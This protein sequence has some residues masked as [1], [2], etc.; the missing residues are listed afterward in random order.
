MSLW[1]D[2][3][4]DLAYMAVNGRAMTRELDRASGPDAP[5]AVTLPELA[6]G[7][8]RFALATIFTEPGGKGPESYPEGDASRAFAVGR[9]Q[10][11]VYLTWRDAGLVAFD[12]AEQL[13]PDDP[14]VGT[15]AGGMGVAGFT[16]TPLRERLARRR[17]GPLSIGILVENA[18]PIRSPDELAWWVERGVVAVGLAWAKPSRYAGGNTSATGLTDLGRKM[19]AEMDRLGVVH[20]A[21]HLSDAAMDEL[22]EES[23]GSVIASH[24][25]CRALLAGGGFGVNQRHLRDESIRAI[26]E[27]GGVVGLNLFAKFLDPA[28]AQST[29]GRPTIADCIRHVEH[30]CELT[31]SRR[32]VGLGSDMDG[33]FSAL[34][35]PEGIDSPRQLDRLADALAARGWSDDD[36]FNFRIGNWARVFGA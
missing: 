31:R 19:V 20:D 26:A 32:H 29:V 30:V 10:L 4:L 5:A 14:G 21:S 7:G 36:L 33:G 35:L 27:R 15:F 17:P 34:R 8:V 12:L 24:S 9:A 6:A 16:P 11:E 1:F 28:L 22:F 18:D 3:H 2:A 23:G 25:N 13:A